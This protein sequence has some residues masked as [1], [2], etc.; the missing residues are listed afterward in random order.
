M[1]FI[2]PVTKSATKKLRVDRRR[3]KVNLPI[4]S[5]LKSSLKKARLAPSKT[6]IAAA[7]SAIDIAKKKKIIK[8]NKAA[9]LKSRLIKLSKKKVKESPFTKEKAKVTKEKRDNKSKVKTTKKTTQKTKK[10]TK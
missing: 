6:T 2:M 9:R 7:Y 4:I 8:P 3:R 1:H 5:R 10:A